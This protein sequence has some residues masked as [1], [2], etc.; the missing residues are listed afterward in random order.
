MV[1]SGIGS[2][3]GTVITKRN[4]DRPAVRSN[5]HAA[6]VLKLFSEKGVEM[7]KD[8]Q[9]NESHMAE[10]AG[11]HLSVLS[12]AEAG[13]IL[14]GWDPRECEI[15]FYHMFKN[16]LTYQKFIEMMLPGVLAIAF[17][18]LGQDVDTVVATTK[19]HLDRLRNSE[20]LGLAEDMADEIEW[21]ELIEP[22][23]VK[24]DHAVNTLALRQWQQRTTGILADPSKT[25]ALSPLQTLVMLTCVPPSP[26]HMLSLG[27]GPALLSLESWS[28]DLMDA[29]DI[30]GRLA[31]LDLANLD[32]SD[33]AT[34]GTTGSLISFGMAISMSYVRGN[35]TAAGRELDKVAEIFVA[36][37]S[38]PKPTPFA[39][40]C[41]LGATVSTGWLLMPLRREHLATQLYKLLQLATAECV[42]TRAQELFGDLPMVRPR[43]APEDHP[44][45]LP[46]EWYSWFHKLGFW[47]GGME[48][49][50]S[51]EELDS[52]PSVTE[53]SALMRQVPPFEYRHAWISVT[54]G[55]GELLVRNGR[56]QEALPYLEHILHTA[57]DDEQF[58]PRPSSHAQAHILRGIAL[59]KLGE[60]NDDAITAFEAACSVS[61]KHGLR[62]FEAM[63]MRD[64]Y[65]H[66]ALTQER[67]T[68]VVQR[69]RLV[70]KEMQSTKEEL[71][72]L[73][74]E[75]LATHALV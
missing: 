62:T 65:T 8:R 64:M 68:Q 54:L 73:F 41:A 50:P 29:I 72:A 27:I 39:T 5:I 1:A 21:A 36:C 70:V 51:S 7:L 32:F 40:M 52:L 49:G 60:R 24:G 12:H 34:V 15:S 31:S 56:H 35:I 3:G 6:I 58:D 10:I 61:Q 9:W 28:W 38:V 22:G 17:K 30:P 66:A 42:A 14:R 67:V 25:T 4:D 16:M 57:P 63:A 2:D 46:I 48:P 43:G 19:K 13:T 37:L 71:A 45:W 74:G 44:G 18:K 20:E 47:L 59:A 33:D 75:D 26:L 53:W 23:V 55:F 69:L 11:N